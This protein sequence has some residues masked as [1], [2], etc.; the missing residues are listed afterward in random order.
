MSCNFCFSNHSDEEYRHSCNLCNGYDEN[1]FDNNMSKY[2]QVIKDMGLMLWLNNFNSN[3]TE[4]WDDISTNMGR[5][6]ADPRVNVQQFNGSNTICVM[7][8]I[9]W[10]A[11]QQGLFE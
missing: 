9:K 8:R 4:C 6:F 7:M 11:Q 5:F 2:I 3:T 10:A 1:I